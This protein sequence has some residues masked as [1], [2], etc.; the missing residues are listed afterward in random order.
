M[1]YEL[2]RRHIDAT[3]DYENINPKLMDDN[4]N[5]SAFYCPDVVGSRR[6]VLNRGGYPMSEIHQIV[7]AET[8]EMQMNLLAQL[9]DYTPSDNPNSGLSDAEIMLGHRSKYCQT[10]S[11]Q[12]GWLQEQYHTRQMQRAVA[13]MNAEDG[14]QKINF[15]N[16]ENSEP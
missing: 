8:V 6:F 15:E 16:N 4:S 14:Q 7:E 2:V 10:A 3:V 13:Q 11:E 9:E 1:D 5:L 12:I